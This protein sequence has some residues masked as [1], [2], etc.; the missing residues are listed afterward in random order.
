MATYK[1]IWRKDKETSGMAPLAILYMHGS[2]TT[3]MSL[4]I[5]VRAKDWDEK[6]QRVL[7]SC[8]DCDSFNRKI[9]T[10]KGHMATAIQKTEAAGLET[11]FAIVKPRYLQLSTQEHNLDQAKIESFIM[12]A[13][14]GKAV[15]YGNSII[16]T[17]GNEKIIATRDSRGNAKFSASTHSERPDFDEDAAEPVV[18]VDTRGYEEGWKSYL[19]YSSNDK[20]ESTCG[21]LPGLKANVDAYLKYA[22]LHR[23][24][25]SFDRNFC[26][27]FKKYLHNVH[28]VQRKVKTIGVSRSTS[29]SIVKGLRA[30]LNWTFDNDLHENA[31]FLKWK[32]KRVKSGNGT[33]LTFQQL[34]PLREMDLTNK[35]ALDRT[36][37]LF[38]FSCYTALRYRDIKLFNE[39]ATVVDGAIELEAYKTDVGICVPLNEVSRGILEKYNG[40]L[41]LKNNADL[42]LEIKELFKMLEYTEEVV[43]IVPREK[44]KSE[45]RKQLWQSVTVHSGR[46]SYINNYAR[47]G[48]SIFNM[49]EITGLSVKVLMEEYY[50]KDKT[51]L[52]KAMAE[53]NIV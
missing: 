35:V 4:G 2:A 1:V 13:K 7:K 28:I 49:T 40:I 48:V 33:W 46:R 51:L 21:R 47:A 39:R 14:G 41:P 36:R 52:K 5:K 9:D 23:D 44:G 43:K 10:A 18:A 30:F 19:E 45:V 38:L 31:A 37:D 24:F 32:N 53:L 20:R 15:R 25:K 42:N 50:K 17:V 16:A 26:M 8:E 3:K 29:H 6:S 11:R 27:N 12:V 34:K 22:N